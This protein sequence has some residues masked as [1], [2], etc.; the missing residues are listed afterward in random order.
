MPK[1]S[2]STNEPA[3]PKEPKTRPKSDAPDPLDETPEGWTMTWRQASNAFWNYVESSRDASPEGQFIYDVTLA[4]FPEEEDELFPHKLF[5]AMW[6]IHETKRKLFERPVEE[7][8]FAVPAMQK[9]F[10][11]V[12]RTDPVR[13]Q[14]ID[15]ERSDG[16]FPDE[17]FPGLSDTKE[18]WG[19]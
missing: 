11:T 10:A 3:L 19:V 16:D 4:E 5:S 17:L 6:N 2:S 9:Y 12:Y 8:S 1:K 18:D 13:R 15:Q 7:I 14:K